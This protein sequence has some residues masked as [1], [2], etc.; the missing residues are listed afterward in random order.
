MMLL[1]ILTFSIGLLF[2]NACSAAQTLNIQIT[3][4]DDDGNLIEGVK[5]KGVFD[6][7]TKVYKQ[8]KDS[9]AITDKNG[10]AF[11][12][13]PSFPPVEVEL[14]KEGYYDT[15]MRVHR[16][17]GIKKYTVDALIREKRNPIAMYARDFINPNR[18]LKVP[19]RDRK[20][21]FDFF[22][23][24]WVLPGYSGVSTDIFF[25]VVNQEDQIKFKKYGQS[26]E[27]S[28]PST[29][30]GIQLAALKKEWR[31]SNYKFHYNAPEEGYLETLQAYVKATVRERT[32]QYTNDDFHLRIRTERGTKGSIIQANYCKVLN[33]F[34]SY[35]YMEKVQP[36]IGF[37]YYCNPTPND[38]NVEFDPDQNLF[39]KDRIKMNP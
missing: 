24:D 21:G 23:G 34:H 11:I 25:K 33:S 36:E 2:V 30:D 38:T 17:K 6:P 29:E 31:S 9:K 26:V 4:T 27:I 37:R 22:K 10:I 19:E 1:R 8:G 35:F 5:V 16:K 32:V 7:G 3:V 20:L 12:S 13:G 39:G 15:N 14:M 18:T 28:F